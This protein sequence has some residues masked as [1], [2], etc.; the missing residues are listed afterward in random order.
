VIERR[1][2]DE[3]AYL[4]VSLAPEERA[5]FERRQQRSPA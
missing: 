5:R 1:D 4:T 2:D 3:F